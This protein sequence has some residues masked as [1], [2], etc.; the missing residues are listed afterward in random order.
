MK[1]VLSLAFLV[2]PLKK[3]LPALC[4]LIT[5]MTLLWDLHIDLLLFCFAS[6][7]HGTFLTLTLQ[8]RAVKCNSLLIYGWVLPM[9]SIGI[10]RVVLF[11]P[12][13]YAHFPNNTPIPASRSMLLTCLMLWNILCCWRW[14]SAH[15]WS[16]RIDIVEHSVELSIFGVGDVE[17]DD[18][19]SLWRFCSRDSD[20][21]ANYSSLSLA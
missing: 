9:L 10:Y 21:G 7:F 14:L 20:L 13:A 19:Q 8:S 1:R 5:I 6:H 11:P 12:F 18:I 4:P 15:P 2:S 3:T 17:I 16:L